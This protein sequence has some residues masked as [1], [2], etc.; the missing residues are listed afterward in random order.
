VRG[1]GDDVPAFMLVRV[2]PPRPVAAAEEQEN[3][4]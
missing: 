1:F 2:R 4:A 3:E